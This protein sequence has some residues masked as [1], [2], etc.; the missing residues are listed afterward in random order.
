V[1]L[2]PP[3]AT[4]D[5]KGAVE[6]LSFLGRIM[7]ARGVYKIVS[8]ASG[9]HAEKVLMKKLMDGKKLT[10]EEREQFTKIV[11]KAHDKAHELA[12]K[13]KLEVHKMAVRARKDP[14]LRQK[15]RAERM[16]TENATREEVRLLPA[17]KT[18]ANMPVQP[19]ITDIKSLELKMNRDIQVTAGID[20]MTH[21]IVDIAKK[22]PKVPTAVEPVTDPLTESARKAGS[23]EEFVA[24][25]G[26]VVFHGTNQ[27]F[28]EFKIEKG[29]VSPYKKEAIGPHFGTEEQAD[30]VAK[31]K[32]GKVK[33]FV[34]DI[35]N[36]IRLE[37]RNSWSHSGVLSQ[38]LEKGLVTRA[39]YDKYV[40]QTESYDV[41]EILKEKG[42][43]GIVYS[44]TAE[45]K[46]DSFI[47]FSNDQIKTT[48]DLRTAYDKAKAEKKWY[49]GGQKGITSFEDG[50]VTTDRKE[51]QKYAD[52]I[53]G[54]GE[55]YEISAKDVVQATDKDLPA[56]VF[57]F[58]GFT[59]N[60]GFIK[61]GAK[62]KSEAK[63]EVGGKVESPVQK[64]DTEK[65]LDKFLT[66]LPEI[67]DYTGLTDQDALHLGYANLETMAKELFKNVSNL[68]SK[69]EG[70]AD[71]VKKSVTKPVEEKFPE[72]VTK[73]KGFPEKLE[74]PT[75]REKQALKRSLK[76]QEQVARIADRTAKKELNEKN[77][78]IRK[79]KTADIVNL[80][81]EERAAIQDLQKQLKGTK[82]LEGLR[83]LWDEISE[84]KEIGKEKFMVVKE[85]KDA[86][87]D[88]K[89]EVAQK[90]IVE[91]GSKTPPAEDAPILTR[92]KKDLV[93]GAKLSTRSPQRIFDMLGGGG[94]FYD[95][96]VFNMY[97]GTV[98]RAVDQSISCCDQ[99]FAVKDKLQELGLSNSHLISK[100]MVGDVE[101][102][103]QQMMGVYA[104]SKNPASRTT[105]AYGNKLTE[106][107]IDAVIAEM[108]PEE[109]EGVELLLADYRTHF[110]RL[111]KEILQ[112][113]DYKYS[114]NQVEGYCPIKRMLPKTLSVEEELMAELMG[115]TELYKVYADHKFEIDRKKI[116]KE[117]QTPM[118][119]DFVAV[120]E[121]QVRLQ[122]H[123]IAM[124]NLV[125]D[126]HTITN[127]LSDTIRKYHGEEVFDQVTGYLN[128]IAN[129]NFY[130]ARTQ[131]E[132][133]L[134]HLRVNAS[135]AQLSLKLFSVVPLQSA[136]FFAALN[137]VDPNYLLG[138]INDFVRDAAYYL[139]FIHERSPQMKHRSLEREF[140]EL[141]NYDKNAYQL[142][143]QKIGQAGLQPIYY[144]DRLITSSVW[145]GKYNSLIDKDY[146][147][148]DAAQMATMAVMRTQPAAHPKDL[149]S[150]YA[151]NEAMNILLSYTNQLQKNWDILTYD[152]P[153]KVGTGQ[154]G[155]AFTAGAGMA[156]SFLAVY[157]IRNKKPPTSIDEVAGAMAEGT[158]SSVPL[159]GREFASRAK[160]EIWG[161]SIPAF[162]GLIASGDAG[163][164]LF[165]GDFPGAFMKG[166]EGVSAF[167][168][169]P[170]GGVKQILD[171]VTGKFFKTKKPRVSRW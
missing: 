70:F 128:R 45:G 140:E 146:S 156:L 94:A 49:H 75:I 147:D 2:L 102:T 66:K 98:N 11:K 137:D 91:A 101:L 65:I 86:F 153:E 54:G 67:V 62:A 9:E 80:N 155:K 79:V 74:K 159:V 138:G 96:P 109:I 13:E 21:V 158:L 76:R 29:E 163:I 23:F 135:L 1:D 22:T 141:K 24:G 36:P 63:A 4:V 126:L 82:T 125:K 17:P 88:M 5:V 121:N 120:W 81:Y 8:I 99:R 103:V 106:E 7:A 167:T 48:A 73:V 39:E 64:V 115:T 12:M 104:A 42:Y 157:T 97:Y 123:F 18:R 93:E 15:L 84:L 85:A 148:Y 118:D 113:H 43:D 170:H 61:L 72:F 161:S 87:L 124:G 112:Y 69:A 38:L 111:D 142:I 59:E 136:S 52:Q 89:T 164:N 169:A 117:F 152:I 166:L 30:F 116:P 83:D 58:D 47:A 150:I 149:A 95:N 151:T 51:A 40:Y 168:G 34:L 6:L 25:Q 122:E 107:G 50:W 32:G 77:K 145:L 16:A 68:Y 92:P 162:S 90:V 14:A 56:G 3:D 44:N 143:V 130:K 105:V 46:G 160:G 110:S 100:R 55:V 154:W 57:G 37:D 144:V 10:P 165:R 71:S 28:K 133:T 139:D 114:L 119:L 53:P 33:E 108:T 129:P 78:L 26:T 31:A 19:D 132:Q 41:R 60:I 20:Y 134:K 131:I 171:V 127:R 35:K 27:E